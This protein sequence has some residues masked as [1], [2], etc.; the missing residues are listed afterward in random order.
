[1]YFSKKG[2]VE[3]GETA[4]EKAENSAGPS[5]QLSDGYE[6]EYA[7][8]RDILENPEEYV[9]MEVWIE[10]KCV[11]A[12]RVYGN[13]WD[14]AITKNGK[15]LKIQVDE[16][17]F[18]LSP[19]DVQLGARLRV[20]GVI[21]RPYGYPILSVDKIENLYPIPEVSIQEI[22]DNPAKWEGKE[23]EVRGTCLSKEKAEDGYW[24]IIGW[25]EL[26]LH[27][28]ADRLATDQRLK[29]MVS[30]LGRGSTPTA[31]GI[32]KL[33]DEEPYLEVEVIY[34]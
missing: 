30:L 17:Y 5:S 19:G 34:H 11:R 29:R 27:F 16:E 2:D 21:M 22:L 1:M 31:M 10:G 25:P 8:I 24:A 33:L 28:S 26:R 23:V 20:F 9:G 15:V 13:N 14:L 12:T 32:V 7:E 6:Y 18:R 3:T 4:D